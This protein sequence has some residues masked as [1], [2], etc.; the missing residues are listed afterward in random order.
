MK[1]RLF[2]HKFIRAIETWKAL[3]PWTESRPALLTPTRPI[4][5]ILIKSPPHTKMKISVLSSNNLLKT[6][7]VTL[8][9]HTRLFWKK[10]TLKMMKTKTFKKWSNQKVSKITRKNRMKLKNHSTV[11]KVVCLKKGLKFKSTYIICRKVIFSW[12]GWSRNWGYLVNEGWMKSEWW[13]Q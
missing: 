11:W 4:S 9:T 10:L 12:F 13:F 1:F 7:T 2:N 5:R 8:I 6:T 3:S